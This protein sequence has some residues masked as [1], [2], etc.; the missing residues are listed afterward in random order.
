MYSLTTNIVPTDYIAIVI[1]GTDVAV[2]SCG[3]SAV[4]N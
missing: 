1:T 3:N 4:T 2:I